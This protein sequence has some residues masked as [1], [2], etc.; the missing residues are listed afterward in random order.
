MDD[1]MG[2]QGDDGVTYTTQHIPAACCLGRL[3][4]GCADSIGVW[5]GECGENENRD[6]QRQFLAQ[7]F[8]DRA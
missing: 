3:L 2:F 5:L 8:A 1:R 6:V 4:L 7:A